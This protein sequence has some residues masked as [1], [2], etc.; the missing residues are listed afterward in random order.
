MC[1]I[2]GNHNDITGNTEVLGDFNVTGNETVQGIL[3]VNN[4]VTASSITSGSVTIKSGNTLYMN[5]PT[6]TTVI[7]SQNATG[8]NVN[9]NMPLTLSGTTDTLVAQNTTDTLTNKTL[10]SPTIN[11]IN[12][13]GLG[14]NLGSAGM[15]IN[16]TKVNANVILFTAGNDAGEYI[17]NNNAG[18]QCAFG[19]AQG[20]GRGTYIWNG[21][22][23]KINCLTGANGNIK[24]NAGTGTV[25]IT[26]NLSAT[27]KLTMGTAILNQP[28]FNVLN[29]GFTSNT[30]Y[31]TNDNASNI[32]NVS[33]ATATPSA[34]VVGNST[35]A[36]LIM[37]A[38][39]A[40]DVCIG[41][42]HSTFSIKTGMS[43][44]ASNLVGS[45][46]SQLTVTGSA[47]STATGG[48]LSVGTGGITSTGA[49][50]LSALTTPQI[51]YNTNNQL[52]IGS[53]TIN[54]ANTQ[55]EVSINSTGA[56]N[57]L[58]RVSRVGAG[59]IY[60]G[61][62][63]TDSVVG[64]DS[65]TILFK[66]GIS[67]SVAD[68]L[69]GGTTQMTISSTTTTV[70]GNLSVAGSITQSTA[71]SSISS[72]ITGGV[73]AGSAGVT[74]NGPLA[75]TGGARVV[76]V[77]QTSNGWSSGFSAGNYQFGVGAGTS[78]GAIGVFGGC[79]GGNVSF[80]VG[81]SPAGTGSAIVTIYYPTP[82]TSNSFV[83]IGSNC[84]TTSAIM[85]QLYITSSASSF[86]LFS[87]GTLINPQ[88]HSFF[89]NASG[90]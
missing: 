15:Q 13:T 36:C 5:N 58:L 1:S 39:T 79:L 63:L 68:V 77:Q 87:A 61:R 31:P 74:C 71:G 48:S 27:G 54:S 34:I 65:G 53:N 72:G 24:L 70:A 4:G 25:A 56:T 12:S 35:V 59:S 75:V 44:G 41:T 28:V 57:Q 17:I 50:T 47:I 10:T 80:T 55:S 81:T 6:S 46:T 89:W 45:G 86:T 78:P 26:G 66:T 30:N 76:S 90:Y 69:S 32:F 8:Y 18:N 2:I 62:I 43:E 22:G 23:D 73:T 11:T 29:L 49:L 9:L 38:N 7:N 85:N 40:S 20:G 42:D 37:G 33:G 16:S 21:T 64:T 60:L 82:F 84:T 52:T 51:A 83:T 88:V 67:Y 3:T 19:T 14:L